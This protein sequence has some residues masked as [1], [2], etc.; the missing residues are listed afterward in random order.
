MLINILMLKVD[1]SSDDTT[2][3]EK[4]LESVLATFI[5]KDEA[6]SAPAFLEANSGNE[7]CQMLLKMWNW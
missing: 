7:S 4:L 5:S 3:G 1:S 2:I 6:V